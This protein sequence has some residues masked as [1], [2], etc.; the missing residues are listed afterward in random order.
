MGSTENGSSFMRR[1]YGWIVYI[2][3]FV[4]ALIGSWATQHML[5][6]SGIA[7]P[8]AT[9]ITGAVALA[10]ALLYFSLARRWM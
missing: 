2:G 9:L 6:M 4:V 5:K 10:A 3:W 1:G 7:G 8:Y